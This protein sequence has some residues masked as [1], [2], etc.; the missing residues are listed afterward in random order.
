M[1]SLPPVAGQ[2]VINHQSRKGS[3]E[4]N[5]PCLFFCPPGSCREDFTDK[6][7]QW[8]DPG[9]FCKTSEPTPSDLF[10]RIK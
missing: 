6:R 1:V 8:A 10:V 4:E 7:K 9:I 5:K 3:E 2:V